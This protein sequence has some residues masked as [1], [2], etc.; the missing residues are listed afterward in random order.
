MVQNFACLYILWWFFWQM[1]LIRL[2]K[3]DAVEKKSQ[4]RTS[5][6]FSTYISHAIFKRIFIILRLLDYMIIMLDL[7]EF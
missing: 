3:S 7:V 6:N 1:V 4:I 5:R 2:P